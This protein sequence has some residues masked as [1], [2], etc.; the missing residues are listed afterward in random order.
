MINESKDIAFIILAA[1]NGTRMKNSTPKVLHK[2]CGKTMIDYVLDLAL[3]F[4]PKKIIPVI[5]PSAEEVI[6][7]IKNREFNFDIVYQKEKLGTGHAVRL[8]LKELDGFV[9]KIIIL[10]GDTPFIS[11]ETV[12]NIKNSLQTNDICVL[13]FKPDDPAKYGRLKTNKD[14]KLEEIIE[15]NEASEEEIRI[16]FCNSGVM[17]F[18]S[19]NFTSLVEKIDNNNN[20]KE[21]YLTDTVQIANK[22]NLKVSSTSTIENEV[23]GINSQEE[24][25]NAEKIRQNYLRDSHLNN[26]VVLIAPETC[27]FS[28]E[29]QISPGTV[30]HPYVIFE[31]SVRIE[32]KCEIKSHSHLSNCTIEEGSSVG[33][34]ARIRPGTT[35]NSNSRV[36]NFVEVKKSTI[37][38]GSKINHLSYIGDSEIGNNVNIGAGT[39]TC[40][41]DGK[42]KHKTSI[43]DNVFIGS[44]CELIAPI[45]IESNSRIGAGTTLTKDVGPGKTIV[46]DKKIKEIQ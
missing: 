3:K 26:G 21:F 6:E 9:G 12:E 18:K 11:E 10:Y 36:G 20:K 34:F 30:I 46:N 1:G 19:N 31:G 4:N 37:G 44:N 16:N 15:F 39:I 33:P 45:K 27:F 7:V 28:D 5:D 38:S 8:C 13:G 25:S 2:I 23:I 32:G 14:G 43:E 17:G 22:N 29:S 35:L 42:N 40:N 41:Y 24:R